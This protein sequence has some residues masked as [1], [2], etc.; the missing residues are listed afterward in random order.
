MSIGLTWKPISAALTET[1]NNTLALLHSKATLKCSTNLTPPIDWYFYPSTAPNE[2]HPI[3]LNEALT[4]T[5]EHKYK[6]NVPISGTYELIIES[7]DWS[8]VGIYLCYD[9]AGIGVNASATLTVLGKYVFN[10]IL[11]HLVDVFLFYMG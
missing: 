9:E 1:P 7:V 6:V 11:K 3:Y 4:L 2:R 8:Y 5:V 10:K